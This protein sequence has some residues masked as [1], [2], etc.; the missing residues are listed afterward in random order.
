MGRPPPAHAHSHPVLSAFAIRYNTV[1]NLWDPPHGD[2]VRA[3]LQQSLAQFQSS[4]RM[5]DIEDE[6]LTIGEEIARIPQGC[7]IGL[8]GGEE[9]LEDYR[10]VN[11]SLTA[12]Q[13]KERRLDA[14]RRI[15]RIADDRIGLHAADDRVLVAD[16]KGGGG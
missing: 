1:L 8:D 7:L 9:L 13:N 3:L 2:R 14:K 12:A 10:R 11:R 4:Q 16:E 5:R 15:G 6:I